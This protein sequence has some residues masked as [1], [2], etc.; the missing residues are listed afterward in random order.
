MSRP[1]MIGAILNGILSGAP[2]LTCSAQSSCMDEGNV[3]SG[4]QRTARPVLLT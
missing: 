3:K 2:P 4:R 1:G